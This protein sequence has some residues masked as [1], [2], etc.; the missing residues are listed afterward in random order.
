MYEQHEAFRK[1]GG[2]ALDHP[3]SFSE[4]P[5]GSKWGIPQLHLLQQGHHQIKGFREARSGCLGEKGLPD[6]TGI[7]DM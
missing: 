2:L 1:M 3:R 7:Q 5:S 4:F 6:V